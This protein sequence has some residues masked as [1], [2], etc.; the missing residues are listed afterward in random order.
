MDTPLSVD[1]RS[2]KGGYDKHGKEIVWPKTRAE[3]LAF[4]LSILKPGTEM[5]PH[6]K[7]ETPPEKYI[8]NGILQTHRM[9]KEERLKYILPNQCL[10]P[11][12]PRNADGSIIISDKKQEQIDA[13]IQHVTVLT[14]QI[15]ILTNNRNA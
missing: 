4:D 10:E 11:E 8:V 14:K 9:T 5:P 15:N 1:A 13:L 7:T 2:P 6:F 3:W 12:V